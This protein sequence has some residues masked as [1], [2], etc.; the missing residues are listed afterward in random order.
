MLENNVSLYRDPYEALRL[1]ND[2]LGVRLWGPP[3]QPTLL[4]GK[5]DIWDRRWFAQRQPIITL[6]KIRELAMPNRL[7]EIAPEPNRTAYNLYGQYDFP[8]PKPGAQ[9]ILGTPFAIRASIEEADANGAVRLLIEGEGK[10]LNATIW[11]ALARALMVVEFQVEGLEPSDFWTRVYRHQDTILPGQPVNPTLGGKPAAEDFEPLPAPRSCQTG[12]YWGIVQ[13]FPPELTFPAGF[14][15]VVAAGAIGVEPIITRRDGE[16]NLGT[17]LW[18]E[19]E[20]RLSHGVIKRYKPINQARGVASTATFRDLPETFTLLATVATTQDGLEPVLTAFETLDEA[21][22]LGLEGL[23][24]EQMI[25][26]QRGRR[27]YLAHA[28]VGERTK[29]SA[30]LIVLP[31]LRREGG[32]YGDVPLCSV[33]STKF[34]FQDSAIWH[35]DFHLNEIRAEPMLTLGQF[36]ELLPYCDMIYTLLGQAQEN[37]RQVYNLPGAM[38]PLVH[39]P[40]RCHGIA[41]TNLTWEQDIGLDGLVSKPLWLYYRYTGDETFL[42]NLA[43][44]VLSECARFYLAYLT[45]EQDGY[46]HVVPTVSPEHWGLTP[47]FERNRDCTSAL[48]LIR[49]VLRA[50]AKAAQIL[51]K[52]SFEADSWKVAAARLAP[53]P[54]Y[55][56][57][58][59]PVWVDVAGAP[60]IEYNIPVPL[61]PVFWGDDVGLDSS[62][63]LLARAKRTMAHIKVWEPHRGYL[64]SCVQPR[65]GLWRPGARLGPENLLLSYQSIR[66]FPAVPPEGEIVMENFAAEGGFRVSAVRKVDGEI[67]QVCIMSLLGGICQV[68][69]PWPG[70]VVVV[71]ETSG[72]EMLRTDGTKTHLM[73][74]TYQGGRYELQT[75]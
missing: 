20:G 74:A 16:C 56:T 11:V 36:E 13:E 28:S 54:T 50:S 45:E 38:Y 22:K 67:R 60:P 23:R 31:K 27:K 48:T 7:A 64:E 25:M 32:Y 26:L 6:A 10:K 24:H 69:N 21:R 58:A 43:Y 47:G 15:F 2:V 51:G 41:H 12:D 17:P 59:G 39:F 35:A 30:P 66:I 3:K 72:R 29:L 19:Q 1:E 68:A 8:C 75:L 18:S 63:E 40:L 14:H 65:L 62:A 61:T 73:F 4:I 44:P 46:L 57:D 37:A 42:R 53:Y 49:Y 55:M 9:V 71:T 70:R 5:A 33:D 52:D 34:C